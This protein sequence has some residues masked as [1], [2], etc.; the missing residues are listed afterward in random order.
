MWFLEPSGSETLLSPFPLCQEDVRCAKCLTVTDKTM[1]NLFHIHIP[2][3]SLMWQRKIH[4]MWIV[5]HG[6][7]VFH[8]STPF[9]VVR[10]ALWQL[11]HQ[12]SIQ[13]TPDA[14]A[15]Q[16]IRISWCLN[17]ILCAKQ[18]FRCSPSSSGF[19]LCGSAV[20][21]LKLFKYCSS[22]F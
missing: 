18:G 15:Q 12:V 10:R 2:V 9:Q 11:A 17:T 7:S 20:L 13:P 19:A 6:S 14:A 3:G 4:S 1:L 21:V 8:P 16:T 22:W 5:Q